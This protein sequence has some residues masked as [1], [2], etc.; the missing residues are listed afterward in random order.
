MTPVLVDTSVWVD[1]F[2]CGNETLVLLLEQDRVLTHPCIL[3]EI[4]CGTP[5]RRAQ[6]L[7]DLASLQAAQQ[8]SLPEML[9][10][11]ERD[12]L[13]GHG[14]GWIDLQLLAATCLSEGAVLWSLDLRLQALADRLGRAYRSPVH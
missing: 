5:R 6:T 12:Q 9:D 11:I 14:C 3:G 8:A 7:A 1:H 2:R 13:F 4:A 10:F